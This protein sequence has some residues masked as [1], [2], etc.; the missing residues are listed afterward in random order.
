MFLHVWGGSV[1]ST[2]SF[3]NVT[4]GNTNLNRFGFIRTKRTNESKKTMTLGEQLEASAL[5][6]KL[7]KSRRPYARLPFQD[8]STD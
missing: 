6:R 5:I 3:L 2:L 4:R 1:Q 8:E 7:G